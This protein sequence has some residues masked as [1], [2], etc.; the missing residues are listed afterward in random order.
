[1]SRARKR[2]LAVAA[3]AF[4][5][6][7]PLTLVASACLD[8]TPVVLPP[9]DAAFAGDGSCTACLELPAAQHGCDD[10]LSACRQDPGCAPVLTCIQ[11]LDCF[12]RPSIDEKLTCGAPCIQEA[13]ITAVDDPRVVA[14]LNVVKCGQRQC[15]VA[16]NLGDG[17][18]GFDAL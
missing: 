4:A 7:A 5:C 16:C 13:G 3:L 14:L 15:G 12:D 11:T 6:F 10:Q 8:V 17:G 1:M 18:L 9:K 2:A